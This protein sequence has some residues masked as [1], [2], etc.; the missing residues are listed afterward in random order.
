MSL[1]DALADLPDPVFADG[2]ES[3]TAYRLVVDLP[4]VTD[5]TLDVRVERGRLHVEARRAK[6]PPTAFRYLREDRALFVDFTLPLV[7]GVDESGIEGSLDHGTLSLTLPKR[8]ATET[9]IPITTDE[10][11][12]GQ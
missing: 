4:G 11:S 1:S 9:S 2:Y 5:E 12:D 8:E 6:T 10:Q 7:P 3:E